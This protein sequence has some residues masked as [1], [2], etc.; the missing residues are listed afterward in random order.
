MGFARARQGDTKAGPTAYH[1]IASAKP[2][3]DYAERTAASGAR[4]SG[5]IPT[6]D[7]CPSRYRVLS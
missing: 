1:A 5:A 6:A 2:A 4:G 7:N 3:R